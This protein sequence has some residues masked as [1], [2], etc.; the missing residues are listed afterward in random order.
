MT[1]AAGCFA[2]DLIRE[3]SIEAPLFRS[4]SADAAGPAACTGGRGHDSLGAWFR[5]S[6]GE[7]G[8]IGD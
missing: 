7:Y 1:P 4:G 5:F 3:G 8:L 6:A 2:C